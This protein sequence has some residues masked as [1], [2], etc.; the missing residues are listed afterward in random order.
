MVAFEAEGFS[1]TSDGSPHTWS[2]ETSGF[3]NP[4]GGSFI[5][6]LPDDGT[7]RFT[8][9]DVGA[10]PTAEYDFDITLG[11]TYQLY[12]RF[13]ALDN[14]ADSFYAEVVGESDF[15]R[16]AKEGE[17]GDLD[18]DF[19]TG[20]GRERLNSTKYSLARETPTLSLGRSHPGSTRCESASG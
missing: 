18:G 12:A 15:Y 5:Q 4:T 11:G 13:D 7:G 9:P 8:L 19:S 14:L 3:L 16:F 20:R 10:L 17:P 2:V 6:A 1:S